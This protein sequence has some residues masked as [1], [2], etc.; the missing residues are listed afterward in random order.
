MDSVNGC[1]PNDGDLEVDENCCPLCIQ[2]NGGEG[3]AWMA[4]LDPL[5]I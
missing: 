1:T 4:D 3:L 2:N 5:I